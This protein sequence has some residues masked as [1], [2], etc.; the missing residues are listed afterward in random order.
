MQYS[1]PERRRFKRV[2]RSFTARV[3]IFQQNM[4]STDSAKWNIVTIRNLSAGGVSFNYS[5]QLPLGTKLELNIALPFTEGP[6]YCIGEVCRID[7]TRWDKISAI[8]IPIYWIA[9][10][11]TE[12]PLDKKE[13]IIKFTNES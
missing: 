2:N 7:K 11:F 3:R 9:V 12:I 13:A 8:K 1:G 5:Q 6:V 4:K 10:R